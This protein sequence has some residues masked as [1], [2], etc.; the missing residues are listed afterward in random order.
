LPAEFLA[1][2]PFLDYAAA[3]FEFQRLHS[4]IVER[5][6]RKAKTVRECSGELFDATSE[7]P[8]LLVSWGELVSVVT[9]R[10]VELGHHALY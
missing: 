5:N 8:I 7:D 10:K 6:K 9:Q 1:S 2:S 4:R 3:R